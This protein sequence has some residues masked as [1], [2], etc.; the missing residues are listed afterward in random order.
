MARLSILTTLVNFSDAEFNPNGAE[1]GFFTELSK[2]GESERGG[3]DTL[4]VVVNK[5]SYILLRTLVCI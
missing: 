3:K 5:C 4:N 2:G 1:A